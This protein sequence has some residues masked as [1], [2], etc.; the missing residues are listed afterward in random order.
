MSSAAHLAVI[1]FDEIVAN[2][3]MGPIIAAHAAGH[4]S[5]YSV[6]DLE[7][8]R[9]EVEERTSKVSFQPENIHYIEASREEL[10]TNAEKWC[11]P[12]LDRLRQLHPQLM[13]YI[14]T[15]VA[16]HE[17][18]LRYCVR[19]NIR[20]LVEKPVLAPL[21][22]GVFAPELI[23]P[24]MGELTNTAAG[25]EDLH[26][27]MILSRYHAI[28]NGQFINSLRERVIRHQ[29]PVTSIHLRAAGGVWNRHDEFLSRDDHPYK[30]GY[31]MLMHGAYHYV[32]VAAQLLEL[33]ALIFPDSEFEMTLS[34]FGA[35]PYDQNIRI[36]RPAAEQL[37]DYQPNWAETDGKTYPLGETDIVSSFWV[38][39]KSSGKV[40]TTGT[41]S[42]EQTTPSIRTWR[43]IP[44]DLYNKNGR[45]SLVDVE[46]Q[47]S[48]LHAANVRVFDLPIKTGLT[49]DRI[50]AFARLETRSNASLLP[51]EKFNDSAT[52][53][54]IF[55]SD[56][57]R[58]LMEHWLA[59]KENRSLL[60]SHRLPMRITQALALCLRQPGQ[61]VT[62]SLR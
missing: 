32:D 52:F 21:K 41:L 56:S 59:G 39:D 61:P 51:D 25:H 50:D 17:W 26:S 43:D 55:H 16:S 33:N 42:F 7:L 14:A 40:L 19:H 58:L 13:V 47:L 8:A 27:V 1:G 53:G 57:N 15:E 48:S 3:Y 23:D 9:H 22:N 24:I 28:Y 49:V 35:F 29:A 11:A 54:G 46:A 2:K 6:I 10:M 36:P 37:N 4:I 12:V 38:R 45:T 44:P 18:Y 31:G 62:I 60:H 5:G 30:Y 20:S 34:G